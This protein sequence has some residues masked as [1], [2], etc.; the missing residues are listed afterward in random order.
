MLEAD[1]QEREDKC[2]SGLKQV[3]YACK[4]SLVVTYDFLL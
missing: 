4:N 3:L 1:V 2:A